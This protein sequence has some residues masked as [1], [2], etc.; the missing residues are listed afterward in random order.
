MNKKTLLNAYIRELV[1]EELKLVL[2][3]EVSRIMNEELEKAVREHKSTSRPE[4]E[5]VSIPSVR[6]SLKELLDVE[7]DR[8]NGTIRARM[9][10]PALKTE[11]DTKAELLPDNNEVKKALT[12]D[13]SDVMKKMGIT[14]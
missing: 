2:R 11:N 5:S 10:N 7:Y 3:S 8:P 13:Y 6:N 1:R 9:I 12:R 14:K 4:S